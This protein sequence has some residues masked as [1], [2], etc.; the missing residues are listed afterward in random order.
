MSSNNNYQDTAIPT[1]DDWVRVSDKYFPFSNKTKFNT[2]KNYKS[3]IPTAVFRGSS[4]GIGYNGDTNIRIKLCEMVSPIEDGYPL[5]DVGI[6]KV[7]KR[8]R[9]V[10]GDS[11]I[12]TITDNN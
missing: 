5:F 6:T 11:T 2:N 7:N 3:K 4:T 8:I 12:H 10:K 9:K 1:W